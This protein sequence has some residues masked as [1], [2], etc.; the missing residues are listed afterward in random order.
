M[1]RDI[2]GKLILPL[3]FRE[4]IGSAGYKD[5]PMFDEK[6]T[7]RDDYKY[8]GKTGSGFAWKGR[9]E[10][11]FISRAPVMM[12][13]LKWAEEQGLNKVTEAHLAEAIGAKLTDE[14]Q[15]VMNGQLWGFLS[16]S[17]SG[18]AETL[19]KG[20]DVLQGIDA[21]RIIT[22]YISQG[23]DIRIETL[24]RDMRAAVARPIPS[25]EKMEEG[26]A[27]FEHAIK[28]YED[29]GGEVYDPAMKKN[30]LLQILPGELSELMLWMA[31]DQGKNFHEFK[32]HV[33][34][35]AGKILFNKKKSPIHAV[36]PEPERNGKDFGNNGEQELMAALGMEDPEDMI[37][38]VMKWKG[39]FNKGG[40]GGG[41]GGRDRGPRRDAA[42]RRDAGGADKD[43]PPRKCPNCGE[44]HADRK[45]P[46]APVAFADRVCWTCGKKNHTSA[47]CIQKGP[48]KAIEDTPPGGAGGASIKDIVGSLKLNGCF[49]VTDG[50]FM[51]ANPR[52]TVRRPLPTQP[53]LASYISKT[54]WDVLS[55]LD[56]EDDVKE[57]GDVTG[58][59]GTTT[60]RRKPQETCPRELAVANIPSA[61]FEVAAGRLAWPVLSK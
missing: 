41:G 2:K 38:A 12:K 50:G 48:L 14:Q 33:I 30:D 28:E 13:I 17:V 29:A 56:D 16:A 21:W 31:T 11:H 6:L 15:M 51:A 3:S 4:H 54:T 39:K 22:R 57:V 60:G 35:M 45:C 40:G 52:R 5:K 47:Q 20:A 10:R 34:T 43:R 9:V 55:K 26:I 53:T 46:K 49:A 44:T 58:I 27:E 32:D 42:P 24:R 18:A 7:E 61:S 59:T 19:F 23:K 36:E 25:L 8:S 37:A 1:P